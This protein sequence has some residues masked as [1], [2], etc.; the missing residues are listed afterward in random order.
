MNHGATQRVAYI[1][2]PQAICSTLCVESG[3]IISY[4]AAVRLGGP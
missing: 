4:R 1:R 3:M 2:Y